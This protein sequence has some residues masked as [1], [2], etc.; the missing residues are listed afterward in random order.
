[1]I[2]PGPGSGIISKRKK[3]KNKYDNNSLTSTIE[4][5]QFEI[6]VSQNL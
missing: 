3:P 1:M 6:K 4:F 5:L 2:D